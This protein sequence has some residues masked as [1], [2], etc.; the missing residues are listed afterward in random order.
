MDGQRWFRLLLGSSVGLSLL[1]AA[2]PGGAFAAGASRP[3]LPKGEKPIV[4]RAKAQGLGA[5]RPA[6]TST[7][8]RKQPPDPPKPPKPPKPK[9]KR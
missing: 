6:G 4:A 5:P 8:K 9:P 2:S 1:A 3:A 7:A